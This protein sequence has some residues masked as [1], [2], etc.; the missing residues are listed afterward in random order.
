M[1][2][3]HSEHMLADFAH[4]LRQPL[5][6]LEALAYYLDLIAAPE[7][8][9]VHEQLRRIHSEIAR[10]D[11][12][13]RDGLCTLSACLLTEG[14]SMLGDVASAAAPETAKYLASNPI[15]RQD[16]SEEKYP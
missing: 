9:R 7:D 3:S 1:A 15:S 11:Q 13:L 8:A 14:R 16:L 6:T 2:Q 10:T 5:S 4:Q 12:I